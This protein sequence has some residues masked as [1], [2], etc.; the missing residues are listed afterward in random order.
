MNAILL[1]GSSSANLKLILSLAQSLGIKAKKLHTQQIDDH[2]FAS[3]IE[4][5]MQT[6]TVDKSEI[7]EVLGKL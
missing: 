5:G 3:R 7:L 4:D 1:E 2:L 6:K